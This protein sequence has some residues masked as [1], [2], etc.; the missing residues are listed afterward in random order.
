MVA[1]GA[2]A[3]LPPGFYVGAGLGVDSAEVKTQDIIDYFGNGSSYTDRDNTFSKSKASAKGLVNFGYE[4]TAPNHY[5]IGALLFLGYGSSNTYNTGS[6]SY[7]FNGT[8]ATHYSDG[9]STKIKSLSYGF[10]ITPGYQ[11]TSKDSI[12]VNLGMKFMQASTTYGKT[13]YTLNSGAAQDT[14]VASSK[15]KDLTGFMYGLG[16]DRKLTQHFS[17][18]TDINYVQFPQYTQ[19]RTENDADL[20][21]R[22]E[23][24]N[25]DVNNLSFDVGVRYH[26]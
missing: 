12:F 2:A 19:K 8:T 18:F 4:Y 14:L 1:T 11:I 3:K 6:Y 5:M 25:I 16:Y 24:Y 21:D 13:W 26:L 7:D 15:D 20:T 17:I 23:T 10:L 22:N 9:V